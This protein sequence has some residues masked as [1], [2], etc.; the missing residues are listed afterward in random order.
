VEREDKMRKWKLLTMAAVA[1][2]VIALTGCGNQ[3]PTIAEN[4]QGEVTNEEAAQ[5]TEEILEESSSEAADSSA[6]VTEE[7]IPEADSDLKESADESVNE[8]IPGLEKN[9]IEVD[10]SYEYVLYSAKGGE[11]NAILGFHNVDGYE[12]TSQSAIVRGSNNELIYDTQFLGTS[13]HNYT[14]VT[15]LVLSA[16]NETYDYYF[17]SGEFNYNP[18]TPDVSFVEKQEME[19]IETKFGKAVIFYVKEK[20]NNADIE[21]EGEVAVLNNQETNIVISYY[22]MLNS[23]YSTY[24]GQYDGKLKEIL[25]T[26]FD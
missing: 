10:E 20:A 15:M 14:E 24:D 11:P 4:E 22:S 26:L 12:F 2:M 19:E 21:Y 3:T 18:I 8:D 13:T 5:E 16:E 7:T 6:E 23:G 9:M 1:G 25:P 17:K